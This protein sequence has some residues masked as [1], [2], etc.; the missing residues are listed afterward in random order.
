MSLGLKEASLEKKYVKCSKLL[1]KNRFPM[2]QQGQ[3]GRRGWD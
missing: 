3:V 1:D 2:K